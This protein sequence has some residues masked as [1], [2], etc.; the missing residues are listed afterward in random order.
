MILRKI[1]MLVVMANA[2]AFFLMA[3]GAVQVYGIN[4]QTGVDQ[5]VNETEQ[6]AKQIQDDQS[7]L[8]SVVGAMQTAVNGVTEL[9]AAPFAAPTLMLNLGVPQFITAFIWAPLYIAA[10]IDVLGIIRGMEI[11]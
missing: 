10:S 3:G 4:P 9:L 5:E 6:N 8:E 1:T 7:V 11:R 2:T